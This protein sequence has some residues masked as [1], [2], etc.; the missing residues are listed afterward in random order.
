MRDVGSSDVAAQ[1]IYSSGNH[2]LSCSNNRYCSEIVRNSWEVFPVVRPKCSTS[3]LCKDAF[4]ASGTW[5]HSSMIC[6]WSSHSIYCRTSVEMVL[7]GLALKSG[8]K[9]V[10]M[11]ERIAQNGRW[12][13]RIA[14]N[15]R[16]S[17][18]VVVVDPIHYYADAQR[19]TSRES[20]NLVISLGNYGS[21]VEV[22]DGN[23][24]CIAGDPS[25]WVSQ[26]SDLLGLHIL[27][28][29][30]FVGVV[31][32]LQ[33]PMERLRPLI[34]DFALIETLQDIYGTRSHIRELD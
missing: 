27:A 1:N 12:N 28:G 20:D 13:L 15:G 11:I 29:A 26:A 9:N 6:F 16:L 33:L 25:A 17:S 21:R 14:Q 22:V 8:M 2:I 5:Q 18:R 19:Q 7:V 34:A 32:F 30:S 4:D 10:Q 24:T 23:G 3:T 31:R